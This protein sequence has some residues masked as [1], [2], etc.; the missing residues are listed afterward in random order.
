MKLM[1]DVSITSF[2]LKFATDR[3]LDGKKYETADIGESLCRV[4]RYYT[5][6]GKLT[7]VKTRDGVSNSVGVHPRL[8]AIGVK[9]IMVDFTNSQLE[10]IFEEN[11]ESGRSS[12]MPSSATSIDNLAHKSQ[13][14]DCGDFG[15][16]TVP[17]FAEHAQHHTTT[18]L[19]PKYPIPFPLLC[20]STQPSHN[21]AVSR[22]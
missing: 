12:N 10:F 17:T 6:K 9:K 21:Q 19:F 1:F 4:L 5:I 16:V 15:A 20:I 18:L 11:G 22:E 7:K 3:A 2:L 13:D 8:K 14:Y